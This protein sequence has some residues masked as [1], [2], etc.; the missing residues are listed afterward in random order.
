MFAPD[1]RI[2]FGILKGWF[3]DPLILSC[4]V[5]DLFTTTRLTP[6]RVML[7]LGIGAIAIGAFGL[8]DLWSDIGKI[9]I[10]GRLDSFY[11]S[12]NYVS[13]YLGP[14]LVLWLGMLIGRWK[15]LSW[16]KRGM[17]LWG[18]AVM[19]I[20]LLFTQSFGGWM[21]VSIASIV[22]FGAVAAHVRGVRWIGGVGLLVLL[23]AVGGYAITEGFSHYN[24]RFKIS[25]L[26][27][28]RDLWVGAWGLIGEQPFVGHGLGAFRDA[29]PHYVNAH[30]QF[31]PYYVDLYNALWPH[32]LYLAMWVES[33]L[34][35]LVGFLV[36]LVRWGMRQMRE[37]WTS[38]HWIVIASIAAMLAIFLHGWLDTPYFKNDLSILFWMIFLFPLA[39]REPAT[40]SV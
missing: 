16:F 25:S 19:G 28:R 10:P 15:V 26:D 30:P 40:P 8:V 24:E 31:Y 35:A 37:Y 22:L 27:T 33:G 1:L 21:T 7:S 39:A 32:Q 29:Y 23:L 17:L 9:K 12:A 4:I 34:I 18:I 2:S 11:E 5:F 14:I 38:P 20:A 6:V 36:F 13:L 3:L